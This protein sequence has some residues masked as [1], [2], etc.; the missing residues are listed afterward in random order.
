M[1]RTVALNISSLP[2]FHSTSLHPY[3][4]HILTTIYSPLPN[5]TSF[6]FTIFFMIC[7]T[8]SLYH[9]YH[10]PQITWFSGES[11]YSICRQLV[12]ELYGPVYRG[13]FSDI[14]PFHC[15][16]NIPVMIDLVEITR[17]LQCTPKT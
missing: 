2:S 14:C 7:T 8:P 5:F 6:H 10:F 4:H 13:M 17:P 11:P 12:P 9:I 1:S 3:S 15:A 16:P